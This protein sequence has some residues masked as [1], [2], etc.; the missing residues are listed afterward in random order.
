M[1]VNDTHCMCSVNQVMVN[2]LVSF[3]K[4]FL[5]S[6]PKLLPTAQ[7]AAIICPFWSDID[8][9]S[10]LG[11]VFYQEYARVTDNSADEPLMGPEQTIFSLATR[12]SQIIMGDT[13]FNPTNV[14]VITWQAVSPSPS[15]LTEVK[16][17]K[18]CLLT[19]LIGQV[20]Y[21]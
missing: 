8:M 2:G 18:C 14:I 1:F 15:S 10:G 9:T 11:N 4:P 5:D 12:H 21:I 20:F 17:K 3:G 19:Y 16:C 7:N 6:K 13:G